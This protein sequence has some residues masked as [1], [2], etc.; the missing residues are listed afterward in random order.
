MVSGTYPPGFKLALHYKD[1]KL[2]EEMAAAAGYPLPVT[3]M[4]LKDYRQLM[5]AGFGEEDISA[6]FRRKRPE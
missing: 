1:L 3:E 6:L 4:T 2:C 5:D